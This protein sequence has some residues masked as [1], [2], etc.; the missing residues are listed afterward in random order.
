MS[1]DFCL[2]LSIFNCWIRFKK[3]KRKRERSNA[4]T[5]KEILDSKDVIVSWKMVKTGSEALHLDVQTKFLIE[6]ARVKC[7]DL[8]LNEP[9]V[10]VTLHK[11]EVHIYDS[12]QQ[13]GDLLELI[14]FK[15]LSLEGI[16]Q[17]NQRVQQTCSSR[18]VHR[19]TTMVDHWFGM[20]FLLRFFDDRWNVQGWSVRT[21]VRSEYTRMYQAIRRTHWRHSCHCSSSDTTNRSHQWRCV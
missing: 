10:L 6:T 7:I 16:D 21:S 4:N 20:F 15:V 17:E 18:Q 11:G 14:T 2:Y 13:I 3:E 8:H 12:D 9:W 5:W 19:T 1:P